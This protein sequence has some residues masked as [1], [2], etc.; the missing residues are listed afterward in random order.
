MQISYVLDTYSAN[1]IWI[2][3]FSHQTKELQVKFHMYMDKLFHLG[4]NLRHLMDFSKVS[5]V[6]C[7]WK[8][9]KQTIYE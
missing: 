9:G 8:G 4:V 2:L 3:S 1:L 5:A 7:L 6:F